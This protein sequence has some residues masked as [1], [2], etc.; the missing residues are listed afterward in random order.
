V[1]FEDLTGQPNPT[2]SFGG[3]DDVY[4][5]KCIRLRLG[6]SVTF[7]GEFVTH[8]LDQACGLPSGLLRQSTGASARFTLDSEPGVIGFFCTTHGSAAGSGMA[9][10]IEVVR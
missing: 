6:Q 7:S 4:S 8:P 5:P 2:V 1:A 10:A 3:L 9:G